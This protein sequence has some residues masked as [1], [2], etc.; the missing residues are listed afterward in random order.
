MLDLERRRSLARCTSL[1]ATVG[2]I[3]FNFQIGKDAA[4]IPLP[5]PRTP[6]GELEVRLDELRRAASS[7]TI[8]AGNRRIQLRAHAT[9]A[10]SRI[11]Q[12]E[13]AHDLCFRFTRAK[14]DPIW[15]I[16]SIELVGN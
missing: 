16:G 12:Q 14:V 15:V 2:Q 7:G 8:S 3:P 9:A 4:K 5:K 6:S 10:A 13:G 11:G 1:R